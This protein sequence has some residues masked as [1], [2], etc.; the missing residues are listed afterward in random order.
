[1]AAG[2]K[3]KA[4]AEVILALACGATPESAALKAGLSLRTVYRR[5]SQPRFRDQVQQSRAEMV[6][7]A[8]G[9]FTAVGMASINTLKS[10]QESAA[11]EAVRLGAARA[12]IEL[13]CKLR[14]TVEVR[15]RLTAL[16]ARLE[17]LLGDPIPSEGV[18]EE[19]E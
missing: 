12:I 17:S 14:E 1:V 4:D 5:L 8:V 3:K 6:R 18:R 7:R 15:E 19:V 10:L 16:E 2:R 13:G 11:S 9:M